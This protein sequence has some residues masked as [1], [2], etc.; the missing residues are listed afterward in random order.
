MG[1]TYA[2]LVSSNNGR[3]DLTQPRAAEEAH[4]VVRRLYP[5]TPHDLIE[6]QRLMDAARQ[7][8]GRLAVGVF[9]DGVLIATADAHLYDP[10][11]LQPR[12]LKLTEWPD[13][14]LLTSASVNDMFAY[15]RWSSG[16]MARC[17]SV[18]A[19]A[20]VRRDW[21]EP[22]AFEDGLPVT[23]ERW[24]DLSNAALAAILR[25]DGD[26]GP[27][28]PDAVEWDAVEL[29]VFAKAVARR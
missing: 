2:F 17:V 18:N 19:V 26:V 28:V 9:G 22:D 8:R 20:G 23:V 16:Q 27:S 24:L 1:L 25:L 3:I 14:R 15:G 7:P 29:H 12:F 21:G 6:T 4:E 10:F 13:V 5:R 11:I